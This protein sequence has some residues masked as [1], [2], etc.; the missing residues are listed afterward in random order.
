VK[1]ASMNK[2]GALLLAL[3][4]FW[5]VANLYSK[6]TDPECKDNWWKVTAPTWGFALLIGVL[7]IFIWILGLGVR[8]VKRDE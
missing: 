8:K 1:L 5:Q 3:I 2:E 7:W 4:A 6:L